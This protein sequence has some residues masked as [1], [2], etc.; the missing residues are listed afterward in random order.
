[1]RLSVKA[2]PMVYRDLQNKPQPGNGTGDA[3]FS[4]KLKQIVM[5][6]DRKE[7]GSVAVT[8]IRV[9]F[10]KNLCHSL[11]A[12]SD[13]GVLLQHTKPGFPDRKAGVV[14]RILRIQ[15]AL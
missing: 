8:G 1:M 13:P 5:H 14:G 12:H 7:P 4:R 3:T 15:D 2:S 10:V 9:V 11:R 6:M